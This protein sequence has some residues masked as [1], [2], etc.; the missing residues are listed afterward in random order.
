MSKKFLERKRPF[1]NFV[2]SKTYDDKLIYIWKMGV[3]DQSDTIWHKP[4]YITNTCEFY[5]TLNEKFNV[6]SFTKKICSC[7]FWSDDEQIP[8]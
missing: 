3:T 4:R 8:P 2:F 5:K 1:Y 6:F 7:A